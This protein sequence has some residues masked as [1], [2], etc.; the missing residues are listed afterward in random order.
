MT[1]TQSFAA[2][3]IGHV[4]Y[5]DGEQPLLVDTYK[6]IV[7]AEN[8]HV[9]GIHPKNALACAAIEYSGD[10]M[11]SDQWWNGFSIWFRTRADALAARQRCLLE[12]PDSPEGAF[13]LLSSLGLA[14]HEID[15]SK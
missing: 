9:F 8:E 14:P 6:V 12:Y 13:L 4:L 7:S 3:Y 11:H 10:H 1:T 5:Q 15:W 2:A